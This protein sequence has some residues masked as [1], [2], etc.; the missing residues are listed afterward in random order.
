MVDEVI[1]QICSD[2]PKMSS[3][4]VLRRV[5]ELNLGV[6]LGALTQEIESLRK[7]LN[8]AESSQLQLTAELL[9]LQEK[10]D[11]CQ[12]PVLSD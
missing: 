1:D 3:A 8:V 12:S 9:S 2:F 7:R 11:A 10:L 4:K 5:L 6:A